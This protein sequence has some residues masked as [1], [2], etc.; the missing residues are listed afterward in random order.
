MAGH[1]HWANIA[2]KK[3]RADKKKGKLF[4]K[5]SKAIIVAAQNGGGDPDANLALRY[6]VDKARKNSMPRDNIE[7]AIKKGTGE[8]GGVR[9]EELLYEGYGP[10]GVALMC[11][12]LTDNRNRTAPEIKKILELHNGNLGTTGCVAWMFERKGIFTLP[13]SAISE[14]ALLEL[15]LEAGAEDVQTGAEEYEV[16][17]APEHFDA[18]QQ[19]LM[20]AN[21]E[22]QLAEIQR[23][24]ANTVDLE[25]DDARLMLKLMEALEDHDDVQN[26]TANFNISDEIMEAVASE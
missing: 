11:E 25:D 24:P 17:C 9:Y 1:S 3:G 2:H 13:T 10:A 18:V 7:R 4:G 21:L 8:A 19:A 22:T 20:E 12:I 14:E 26:I 15:A 16:Q 23:I 5:L 6:A